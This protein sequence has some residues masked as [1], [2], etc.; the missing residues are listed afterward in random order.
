VRTPSQSSVE[1][2]TIRS[3][4]VYRLKYEEVPLETKEAI[5]AAYTTGNS[6]TSIATQFHVDSVAVSRI[7]KDA[8]V[9]VVRKPAPVLPELTKS[10]VLEAVRLYKAGKTIKSIANSFGTTTQQVSSKL[11]AAGLEIDRSRG[12]V[13]ARA[14]NKTPKISVLKRYQ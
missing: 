6:T 14:K 1:P 9:L 13:L 3:E 12:L 8:G 4:R 5:V 7:I 10:Q 2:A 11:R